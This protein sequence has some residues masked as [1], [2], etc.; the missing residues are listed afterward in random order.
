[1][2]RNFFISSLLFLTILFCPQMAKGQEKFSFKSFQNTFKKEIAEK[3]QKIRKKK[4]INSYNFM[5]LR[6]ELGA[7]NAMI[8]KTQDSTLINE[9]ILLINNLMDQ[10]KQS[11]QIKKNRYKYKDNY[12]GWI[13]TNSNKRNQSTRYKEVPLFESY[14]FFY[15]AQFL[16]ILKQNGWVEKSLKNKSWWNKTLN[17]IENNEWEK[18]Y[19]RSIRPKGN[20]YWY[21]LRGRTHMGSHWAGIAMYLQKLT[22]DSRVYRQAK[23]LQQDYDKLLRRNLKP[24]PDHPSAYIWH[25]TY[26]DVEGTGASEA[27]KAIIQDVSHGNH[28]VSYIVAAYEMGDG[29]WTRDDVSKLANTVKKVIYNSETNTFY[30]DV[31]GTASRSRPGWGNFVGDGWVKLTKYDKKVYKIF[32]KFATQEHCYNGRYV[33]GN[34]LLRKYNQKL[35]Y[36]A[37]FSAAK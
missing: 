12:K 24:N 25:S 34:Y 28:V 14:S 36:L 9:Q 22:R 11:D 19:S 26:D 27:D 31:D 2:V 6:K 20:H 10:A 29:N 37:N 17:F 1:M 13:V 30:D 35:Q 3:S 21:F 18:W 33:P 7:L 5:S 16:Y 15:I 8:V 4:D 23:K 32:K